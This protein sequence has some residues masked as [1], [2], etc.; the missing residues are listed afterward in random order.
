[1]AGNRPSVFI[2]GHSKS[3]TTALSRFLSQHPSLFM[4]RPEEPNFFC[5]SWCGPADGETAFIRRTEREY[6]ELFATATPGAMCGEA[7][8][9]Y[10]YSPESAGLIHAFAPQAKII[11][12]FREPV[13]F[14]RSYHLQLLK[15]A[16]AE[17][18]TETDLGRALDLEPARRLG[19]HLPEGCRVP[20]MLYYLTERL[21]YDV[22]FDRYA[23]LFP[24]EQ[25]LAL[26]YD[27]LRGD[28]LGTVRR[29][30]EFLGV[31]PRFEP[32]LA[33]HNV[34]G[35]V[36]KSRRSAGLMRRLTHGH[37]PLRVLKA[38]VPRRLR[39]WA[40]RTAYERFVMEPAPAV[41][42]RVAERIRSAARPHVE[43]LGERLDR[44]LLGQWGY[45]DDAAAPPE[46]APA[47][48]R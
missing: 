33:E 39:P 21:A 20:E 24:R 8:A 19:E 38:L 35:V 36:L 15:S 11:M 9:T 40:V 6:L 45:L 10:L 3:G 5:P 13:S 43:A 32:E 30:C 14:L 31:D 2:V 23:M 44:D 25:I 42:P 48:A 12:I 26:T 22:H 7:S 34:G 17:G 1:M 4:V 47:A 41:E 18:E 46:P 27:D 28:N 29:V 37:G 16:P